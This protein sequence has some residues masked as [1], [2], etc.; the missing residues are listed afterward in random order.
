LNV[1]R[2][3]R[4]NAGAGRRLL[5]ALL[6]PLLVGCQD[7]N[8]LARLLPRV[9]EPGSGAGLTAPF[10]PPHL[11]PAPAAPP[12]QADNRFT[13]EPLS[14]DPHG[15]LR[16]KVRIEAGGSPALVALQLLT[17]LFQVDGRDGPTYLAQSYFQENPGRTPS[18]IQPGDQFTLALPPDTFVI[19]TQEERNESFGQPA[20][21]IEYVSERGDRL[22][23]YLTTPF[24]LRYELQ[25]AG[26]GQQA[27]LHLSA[28]LA[29]L[30]G[31]GQTDPLRLARL[32]YRLD[33]PDLFQVESMRR[34]AGQVKPG[35][36]TVLPIDRSLTY[37]DPVR[38]AIAHAAAT[39]PVG[40]PN[41]AN[42]TRAIMAPDQPVP[43]LAVE[44]GLGERF[45]LS[46]IEP[47]QVFR[48]TY[49]RDGTVQVFERTSPND[50]LR[51]RD[52]YEL[53]ESERWAAL[54]Q[55]LLP[56]ADTPV[57]WGPG[58]PSDLDPF[59]TARDPNQR[60]PDPARAYDYLL[61]GRVLVLTFRPTRSL[62]DDR[63]S[64]E[65]RTVLSDLR[66]R[67]R[68][69]LDAVQSQLN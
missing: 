19:R 26:T 4:T 28:D 41:R 66:N 24:P 10:I 56:S 65:F 27:E 38:E 52:P 29:Y 25:P 61:S 48:I 55:R 36:E 18:S 62:S 30:L 59:P 54:Y 60:N 14:P 45:D 16:Y 34:L 49:G 53:R 46:Q 63:A 3:R 6:L 68:P 64:A 40:E 23:F 2:Q 37:L 67:L 43:L 7:A 15:W 8:Q 21:L 1:S 32:V 58:E 13:I 11:P 22:R 20:R 44:D 17:P 33:A 69:L 57:K 9:A 50:E 51:R 42:L 31:S 47:G 35:T 39:E 5:L 12:V